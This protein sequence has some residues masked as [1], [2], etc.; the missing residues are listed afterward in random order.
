MAEAPVRTRARILLASGFAYI[1]GWADAICIMRWKA[2]ATMMTGNFLLMGY[3]IGAHGFWATQMGEWIPDWVF[4]LGV[5]LMYLLGIIAY[6]GAES[7]L[8]VWTATV[9]APVAALAIFTVEVCRVSLE[10]ELFPQ[11]W[12]CALLAP[13]FAVMSAV[14][15]RGGLGIPTTILTGHLQSLGYSAVS[16]CSGRRGRDER[17]KNFLQA[18]VIF[19][20]VLGACCGALVVTPPERSAVCSAH[21]DCTALALEGLCCPSAEG[22]ELDCCESAETIPFALMPIAP[23]LAV[24]LVVHDVMFRPRS[25]QGE[26]KDAAAESNEGDMENCECDTQDCQGDTE[27][28][29]PADS[30]A[31]SEVDSAIV[32][33]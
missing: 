30:V 25:P 14:S 8:P 11:R 9:F 17:K 23:F 33:V 24:L 20:Q 2:F 21:P 6:R 19:A 16:M 18:W 29:T 27:E 32:S 12:D 3:N 7:C 4:H 22:V 28:G 1:A 5:V 26:G 31:S 15:M 13:V 10:E